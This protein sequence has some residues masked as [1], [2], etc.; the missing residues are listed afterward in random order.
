MV[1]YY[2][3]IKLGYSIKL[4]HYFLNC[5]SGINKKTKSTF[6]LNGNI[7]TECNIAV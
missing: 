1:F 7:F 3:V 2:N 5:Y 4:H 6:Y